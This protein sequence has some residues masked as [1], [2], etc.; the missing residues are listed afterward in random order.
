MLKYQQLHQDSNH[1][2][3]KLDD[4]PGPTPLWSSPQVTSFNLLNDLSRQ[5]KVS[6]ASQ[7]S[8]RP[9]AASNRLSPSKR[10]NDMPQ[11]NSA[12]SAAPKKDHHKS[13]IPAVDDGV[14]LDRLL[15]LR[16]A[17]QERMLNTIPSAPYVVDD[18]IPTHQGGELVALPCEFCQAMVPANQLVI[19]ETGCRP[20]LAS[21]AA[22]PVSPPSA[23]SE[24]DE[25]IDGLPCEFCGVLFPPQ[26][27]LQH[28][29][30]C[31]AMPSLHQGILVNDVSPIQKAA[32]R[33]TKKRSNLGPDTLRFLPITSVDHM[34]DK[35]AYLNEVRAALK[36]PT[37]SVQPI[38][39]QYS[40]G[41]EFAQQNEAE[42][43]SCP[44]NHTSPGC[45]N[46]TVR[47]SP[48]T[49]AVPKQKMKSPK[50]YR[51]PLPPW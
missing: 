17:E 31:D 28:Q 12:T 34:A 18:G 1:S 10:T 46:G 49:G 25:D 47:H 26:F 50:K 48:S 32:C 14:D 8:A 21:Y 20:D 2:F 7:D 23:S 22:A 41:S 33:T 40:P 11:V 44:S 5:R 39:H 43:A 45:V 15:A 3:L 13:A 35:N 27:L 16:L 6:N 42:N 4:E 30:V 29:D 36:K 51:A 38:G 37:A 19:H 9:T 24:E